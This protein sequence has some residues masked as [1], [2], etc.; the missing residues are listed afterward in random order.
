MTLDDID[1]PEAIHRL[2]DALSRTQGVIAVALGGSRACGDADSASDWDL[3][4]Y[5]RGSLDLDVLAR[6]GQVHPPGAWGR[7][8]NGGA[9]LKL[10]GE[11]VDVLLRDLDVVEHWSERARAGVFEIDAL[12]GY[13]AGIPTY[14]LLAEWSIA[15]VLTGRLPSCGEYPPRLSE[16]APDRWR[17]HRRFTIEH[18]RSRAGRGDV[19]GAAGQVAKAI[20]EEAHAR[21]CQQRRWVLNEKRIVERAGL[22]HGQALF[23]GL[24]R[25]GAEELRRW[26]EEVASFLD[27]S[28]P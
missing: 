21:L 5:Y 10:D 1:P 18:A 13:I 27:Q 14:S 11:K 22:G 6:W 17:F 2:L 9:W 3:G 4:V 7:I 20:V 19:V 23:A 8:M 15:R 12:L 16:V 28:P 26:V 25:G 24:P